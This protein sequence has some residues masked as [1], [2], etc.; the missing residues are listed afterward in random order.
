MATS[1]PTRRLRSA[2]A[3]PLAVR[4][5]QD[6]WGSPQTAADPKRFGRYGAG[7][8]RSITD[9]AAHNNALWCDAVCRAHDRP[10]EFYDT[11]WLTRLGTPRFYPDAVTIAGV[12]AAPAQMEAIAALVGSTRRREWFVKDS[13]QSL[14]LHSLGFEP[15][16]DAEWVAMSPPLPDLKGHPAAEYRSA[17]VT[18][19]AGLIAWEQA[20]AG[21]RKSWHGAVPGQEVLC[22]GCLEKRVGRTLI[23]ISPMH[24]LMLSI[25]PRTTCR[26]ECVTGSRPL[27]GC[28]QVL[29][30]SVLPGPKRL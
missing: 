15:V 17:S 26:I 24:R 4:A 1:S 22:I 23:A 5:Q 16:F 11:L 27:P 29:P 28:F 12:E 2:A 20:W 9:L 18:S 6:A 3:W 10:G 21:R 25:I 7:M 30:G 19:K 8:K 13:F 14:A